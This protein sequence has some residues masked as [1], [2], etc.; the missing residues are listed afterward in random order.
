MPLKVL[1]RTQRKLIN[2]QLNNI[3]DEGD[4]PAG[5]DELNVHRAYGRP[6]IVQDNDELSEYVQIRLLIARMK[7]MKKFRETHSQA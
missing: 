5:P 7:A 4:A 1:P 3:D 6:K 2:L